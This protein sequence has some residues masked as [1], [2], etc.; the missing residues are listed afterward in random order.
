MGQNT[1]LDKAV[2]GL[3]D[4]LDEHLDFHLLIGYDMDGNR[5]SFERWSKTS[6]QDAL[7]EFCRHFIR[8]FE[9]PQKTEVVKEEEE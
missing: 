3:C 4:K 5:H 2:N 6:Q 7:L 1:D 8:T 9:F